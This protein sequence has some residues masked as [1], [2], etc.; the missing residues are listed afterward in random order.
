MKK[1][2][3][4]KEKSLENKVIV[5]LNNISELLENLFILEALDSNIPVGKIKQIL[6][7]DKKRIY[8]ISKYV[9]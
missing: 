5:K 3:T 9:K 8:A 7:I 2:K 6:K 4:K 1:N